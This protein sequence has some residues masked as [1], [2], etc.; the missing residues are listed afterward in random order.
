MA[1][2]TIS[3]VSQS[4]PITTIPAQPLPSGI[5]GR[6]YPPTMLDLK[7]VPSDYTMISILF[8]AELNWPFVVSNQVASSQIFA[9]IPVI[10]QTA[11]NIN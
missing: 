7:Q 6:I 9:Y 2:T 4:G 11:L 8:D 3:P 10:I 1:T 5:P